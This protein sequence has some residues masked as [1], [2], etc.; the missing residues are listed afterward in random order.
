MPKSRRLRKTK[1]TRRM[2]GGNE[3]EGMELLNESTSNETTTQPTI[4]EE[5]QPTIAEEPQ[6]LSTL[7][8]HAMS[9]G[10]KAKHA[11]RK[12]VD[13]LKGWF[14]VGNQTQMGGKRRRKTRK[15]RK[16]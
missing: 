14:G 13:W 16:H 12:A 3:D 1:R 11:T 6:P 10:E 7:K 9:I 5:P 4:T 8:N 2:R 15:N